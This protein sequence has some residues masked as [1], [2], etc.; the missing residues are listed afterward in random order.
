MVEEDIWKKIWKLKLQERLK[1]NIWRVASSCFQVASKLWT[2][3][4]RE[5][6]CILCDAGIKTIVHLLWECSFARAV[7]F[8]SPWGIRGRDIGINNELQLAAFLMPTPCEIVSTVEVA[9]FINFGAILIEQIWKTRYELIYKGHQANPTHVVIR[10]MAATEER[11]QLGEMDEVAL[12]SPPADIHAIAQVWTPPAPGS[13]K[14]NVDAA[15]KSPR[16]AIGLIVRDEQG[17]VVDMLTRV[18]KA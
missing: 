5:H 15:F 1:M 3:E 8:A 6:K 4:G 11:V 12:S 17:N 14:I 9:R 2:D 18:G 13:L 7:W 10:I 16:T